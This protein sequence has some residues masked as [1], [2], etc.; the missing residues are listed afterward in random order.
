[1]AT[2][3]A[4]AAETELVASEN[5]NVETDAGTV[6]GGGGVTDGSLLA[7]AS[8][9]PPPGAGLE[10]VPVHC[11]TVPPAGV[12]VLQLTATRLGNATT[13]TVAV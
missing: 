13:V 6:M 5:W 8:S 11:T 10:S 2:V 9:Q 1:M 4:V 12:V 3:T 7:I